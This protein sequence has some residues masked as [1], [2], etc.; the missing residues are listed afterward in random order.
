M[1]NCVTSGVL[2]LCRSVQ[3]YFRREYASFG[4]FTHSID[5][6][7]I[8][9]FCISQTNGTRCGTDRFALQ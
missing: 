7:R 2:E 6:Q 8:V 1:N 4:N 5:S 3:E 9:H